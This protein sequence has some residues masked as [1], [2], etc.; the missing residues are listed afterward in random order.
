[1]PDTTLLSMTI[2][3]DEDLLLARSYVRSFAQLFSRSINSGNLVAIAANELLSRLRDLSKSIS[4]NLDAQLEEGTQL[5]NIVVH[6][7]DVQIPFFEVRER[8]LNTLEHS[9]QLGDHGCA[10]ET[11]DSAAYG[12][13]ITLSVQLPSGSNP[14]GKGEVF[15]AMPDKSLKGYKHLQDEFHQLDKS[16]VQILRD[17]QPTDNSDHI[18]DEAMFFLERELQSSHNDLKRLNATHEQSLSFVKNL[19]AD[20]DSIHTLLHDDENQLRVGIAELKEVENKLKALATRLDSQGGSTEHEVPFEVILTD[21]D[22]ESVFTV[23]NRMCS[24]LAKEKD[25][26]LQ[27]QI[28]EGV[29]ILHND[30]SKLTHIIHHLTEN[31]VK[32][33]EKGNIKVLAS[34]RSHKNEII[35]SVEDTGI[36]ISPDHHKFVFGEGTADTDLTDKPYSPFGLPVTKATI[37]ALGGSISLDSFLGSGSKFTVVI[38]ANYALQQEEEED[39]TLETPATVSSHNDDNSS[40]GVLIVEDDEATQFL[41]NKILSTEFTCY[42]ASS[43]KEAYNVLKNHRIRFIY[44]DIALQG[45]IDGI[46]LTRQIRQSPEWNE[47]PIVALTSFTHDLTR[48]EA[49][50]AGVDDYLTKPVNKDDVLAK[51]RQ[52]AKPQT[53][54]ELTFLD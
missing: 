37:E 44:M 48:G 26:T 42:T 45:S 36:G 5:L 10:F 15:E 29:P 12:Q 14:V 32:Y 20:I 35:F 16:Y 17:V 18:A 22:V 1:M 11:G 43:G 23:V 4:L 9:A 30:K 52:H 7:F 53:S 46:E 33:S 19:K 47:I 50:C 34:V 24:P 40:I 3:N 27:F 51:V 41:M 2:S 25:L 49:L 21:F 39:I 8:V 28:E 31:A 6:G 38:P 13:A 54:D